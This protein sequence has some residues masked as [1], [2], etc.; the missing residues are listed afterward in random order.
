MLIKSTD[1]KQPLLAQL[2]NLLGKAD[3][4]TKTRIE[5][6]LRIMRAGIKGEKEAAY[7]LDFDF[8][9]SKN[10]AVIHDLRLEINGR[11][12]QIDHL[13][14]DRMLEIYVLETKHLKDSMKITEDGE[15]MRWNS[16]K[17]THEGMPSPLAQNERHISVLK[18]AVQQIEWP[19]RLGLR[20]MPSFSSFILVSPG[21]RIDRPKKFDT[22]AIIKAD[23]FKKA[24]ER[25]IEQE[26]IIGAIGSVAKMVSSETLEG[27][28]RQMAALHIPQHTSAAKTFTPRP[29][30]PAIASVP[31]QQA[32][33]VTIKP[34][35]PAPIEI[36]CRHCQGKTLA[37]SYGK[38]GYYFKCKECDGNTPIQTGCAIDGHRERI[39]KDGKLFYRECSD[40]KRSELYW[41]N[42]D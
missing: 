16:Y 11:V 6:K 36:S 39:R 31:E 18:D 2:E 13:L 25:A 21:T 24:R 28:A 3:P 17:K 35:L 33:P 34:E 7:L 42:P 15:F 9:T 26:G 20:L 1:D 23:D 22:R 8:T 10:V 38:Y 5:E 30:V 19:T 4:K 12:A 40:C 27:I 14:I 29:A 41:T 32:A 37:I